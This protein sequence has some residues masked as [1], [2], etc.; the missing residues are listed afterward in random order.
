MKMISDL[1]PNCREASRLQSLA[2]DHKL[3]LRQRIGLR[4][5]LFICKWCRRYGKQ[6]HFLSRIAREHPEELAEPVSQK[7]SD[8]ARERIK[9]SLRS[10]GTK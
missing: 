4:I 6:L 7:L 1:S 9:E 2:L 3:S 8:D 10:K 5:H